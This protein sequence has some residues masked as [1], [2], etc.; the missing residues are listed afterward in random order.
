MANIMDY[1]AWRGDVPFETSPLNEVDEYLISIIGLLDFEGIVPADGAY[2]PLPEAAERYFSAGGETLLGALTSRQVAPAFRAM[3]AAPRY[4]GLALT[5]FRQDLNEA[6]GEQFSALTVRLPD[7]RHC[8]TFR[9]TD[10]TV[11]GWKENFMLTVMDALPSQL[12]ALE[13]LNWAASVYD[14]PLL[15]LGHSKG[16]NLAIY[17]AAK[18]EPDVKVRIERIFNSDGPGFLPEFLD[19]PEFLAVRDKICTLVPEHS[20]IGILLYPAAEF[21]IVKSGIFLS[22][23][24]DGFTW[25][26]TPPGQ[27][28]RC[29]ELSATS[30][31]FDRAVKKLLNDRTPEEWRACIEECFGVLSDAGVETLTD[32]TEKQL[33]EK[34][35]T[36]RSLIKDPALQDLFSDT[37]SAF[38]REYF[39]EHSS[40]LSALLAPG[41]SRR[42]KDASD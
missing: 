14:G 20:M 1:I 10:D 26:V 3:A 4:T 19:T 31:T 33:G 34:L 24:H 27:F 9:G 39:S 16:G 15:L 2:I 6:N 18:T 30:R 35:L 37:F 13:Y 42:E 8:I 12:S 17:A 28:T 32:L 41:R 23:S 22:G 11:V 21:Q 5:G 38:V 40:V 7:G 25:E 36:I 29:D